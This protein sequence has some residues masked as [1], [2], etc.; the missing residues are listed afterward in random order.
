MYGYWL[1]EEKRKSRNLLLLYVCLHA[2]HYI[3]EDIEPAGARGTG[4]GAKEADV[5]LHRLKEQ[6]R[7]DPENFA[8][9]P[10]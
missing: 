2:G 6:F 10:A 1:P 5:P 9:D 3:A 8:P 4:P 7:P